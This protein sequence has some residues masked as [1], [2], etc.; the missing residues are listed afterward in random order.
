MYSENT[1]IPLTSDKNLDI[2]Q[3]ALLVVCV[4][5]CCGAASDN[6]VLLGRKEGE[7]E[8][9]DRSKPATTQEKGFLQKLKE[10]FWTDNEEQSK[11]S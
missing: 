11:K 9:R 4:C 2:N 1:S 3:N 7:T 5:A 8:D 6:A 10:V